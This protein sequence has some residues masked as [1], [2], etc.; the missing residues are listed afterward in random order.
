M[1]NF[2]L[3]KLDNKLST[4][5][6]AVRLTDL[7]PETYV[8]CLLGACTL[9]LEPARSLEEAKRGGAWNDADRDAQSGGEGIESCPTEDDVPAPVFELCNILNEN[10]RAFSYAVMPTERSQ[11]LATEDLTRTSS[12]FCG[13]ADRG[14][15][16]RNDPRGRAARTERIRGAG[17]NALSQPHRL[18]LRRGAGRGRPGHR[19]ARGAAAG[20]HT[21]NRTYFGWIV[22]PRL[23]PTIDGGGQSFRQT[24]AFY[25]LSAV[26]SVPSWWR[27]LEIEVRT[28]W[29]D[30]NRWWFSPERLV[31][32]LRTSRPEE[33]VPPGCQI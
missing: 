29:I 22:R 20:R 18:R 28:A 3:A 4:H 7:F 25:P 5:R 11:A 26:V 32:D 1:A 23:A 8:D 24:P 9:V 15:Q 6:Y 14:N 17:G 33:C 13:V 27:R 16:W 12:S 19:A 2:I 31:A 21:E 10:A 30:P